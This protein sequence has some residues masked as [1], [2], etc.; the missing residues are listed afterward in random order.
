MQPG[1]KCRTTHRPNIS[2]S[3]LPSTC[4]VFVT[5][6]SR[7]K[8]AMQFNAADTI[9]SKCTIIP[10]LQ[11]TSP[12]RVDAGFKQNFNDS[13]SSWHPMMKNLHAF[14]PENGNA[15]RTIFQ[16]FNQVK[17]GKAFNSRM[18]RAC[19]LLNEISTMIHMSRHVL[20]FVF[21]LS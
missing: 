19:Q 15:K 12:R 3:V 6:R 1:R 7:L 14:P 4:S 5:V 2:I 13:S 8:I 21:A 20:K 9:C 10:P 17:K 18:E 16:L 11:Q